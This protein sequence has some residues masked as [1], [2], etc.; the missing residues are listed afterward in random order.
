[1]QV[2]YVAPSDY[3]HCLPLPR[4]VSKQ[5]LKKVHSL[6]G[7]SDTCTHNVIHCT[8]EGK[9]GGSEGGREGGRGGREGVRE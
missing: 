1:M 4:I 9:G 2:C 7:Y 6:Y 5:L 8:L 3:V